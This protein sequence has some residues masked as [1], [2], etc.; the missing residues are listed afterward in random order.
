MQT[1]GQTQT[2]GLSFSTQTHYS[3]S[4]FLKVALDVSKLLIFLSSAVPRC[5]F[6]LLN[7]YGHPNIE[8]KF[9]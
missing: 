4:I 2:W 7:W 3:Q 1:G 6:V 9:F 5:I 8:P